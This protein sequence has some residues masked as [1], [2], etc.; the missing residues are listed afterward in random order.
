MKLLYVTDL[1][2]DVERYECT[3]QV[4]QE[5]GVELVV[6]G[7][8]LLPRGGGWHRQREFVGEYLEPYLT[9]FDT[10]GIAYLALLGNDDLRSGD[11]LFEQL[12]ERLPL[13]KVLAQCK[14]DLGM[15]EFIGL[16]WVPDFPFRLKD[17][18]RKDTECSILGRQFGP[19]LLS[20]SQGLQEIPDWPNYVRTL[21]TIADELQRLPRPRSLHHAVYVTHTP[22][23]NL[24]L[25]ACA[26]G[27]RPGSQAVYEFLKA[28]QPRL[29]LHGHIHESPQVSG[30]W[31]ARLGS[32]LCLQ[33]G[34]FAYVLGDLD[35]MQFARFEFPTTRG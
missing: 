11:A 15:Y 33:P 17:R 27:S 30:I 34:A 28:N 14:V 24:G 6:N 3:W 1:H 19:G 8:D 26:D 31:Q 32:T 2:G 25:D 20:S 21:P 18:A 13:V 35:E 7:G 22:P 23:A 29:A 9:R 10:A 12:G 4:A 5:A 16:N